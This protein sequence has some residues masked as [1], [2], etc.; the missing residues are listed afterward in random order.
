MWSYRRALDSP[1][2]GFD[3]GILLYI[4]YQDEFIPIRGVLSKQR[5]TFLK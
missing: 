5:V 4:T 3:F 2:V 1:G